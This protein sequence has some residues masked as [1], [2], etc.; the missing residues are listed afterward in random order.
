[1]GHDD[2]GLANAAVLLVITGFVA[3]GVSHLTGFDPVSVLLAFAP[4][5]QTELN[6][7][8]YV[9]GLD[10]AYVALHH[11]TRLAVVI[12]GAQMVFRTKKNWRK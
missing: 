12:L 7:L 1:M 11:L 3:S 4:G 6:L 8:A 9:L 10:V 5:G 2:L